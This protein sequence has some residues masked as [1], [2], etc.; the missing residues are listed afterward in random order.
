M[1]DL[2]QDL[3]ICSRATK[4]PWEVGKHHKLITEP[5][6]YAIS[7][8][9]EMYDHAHV[10]AAEDGGEGK[11]NAHLMA[12]S[13]EALPYWIKKA[14]ARREDAAKYQKWWQDEA[15]LSNKLID[16]NRELKARLE[17]LERVAEAAAG[18]LWLL[19][20]GKEPLATRTDL[21]DALAALNGDGNG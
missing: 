18:L 8:S 3:E 11:A 1:R 10:F 14:E 6:H 16:E 5:S 15:E 19:E 17:K 21:E 7:Q 13:R 4:G 12:T 2:Q 9:G 20:Q